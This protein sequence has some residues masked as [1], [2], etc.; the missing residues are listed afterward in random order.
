[1]THTVTITSLYSDTD[2]LEYTVVGTCEQYC[3]VWMPCGRARC[4]KPNPD[5]CGYERDVH[6]KEHKFINGDWCIETDKCA[7]MY[8][9]DVD[10]FYDITELGTYALE[11]EWDGDYW[12]ATPHGPRLELANV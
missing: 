10:S 6:G 1:M 8:D 9:V 7:L 12:Y 11:I 4:Q 3:I 2:D 5:Y